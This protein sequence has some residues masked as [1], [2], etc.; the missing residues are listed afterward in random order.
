MTPT[1]PS[2]IP[3]RL[4]A[5]CT[6]TALALFAGAAHAQ[7][8]TDSLAGWTVYGDAAAQSGAITLTTAYLDGDSDQPSNLSGASAVDIATLEGGVG[9]A[10]YALD[11]SAQEYGTEGSAVAQSFAALAGQTLSFDWSFG[12]LETLFQDRAFVVIDGD[13]FTLATLAAPGAATQ[14]FSYTFAQSGIASL[15][16]GVIDTV[17]YLGVSTLNV[18]NLQVI[19]AVPEPA[20]TTM[21]LAGLA[22]VGAV[23][24]RRQPRRA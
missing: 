16:F 17:D 4:A 18:S 23:V 7:A 3:Q 14:S 11:L 13:V 1:M 21:V 2:L 8:T 19:S 22:F 15:A 6:L 20:T 5:A 10:P 9:V 12:T 24:R